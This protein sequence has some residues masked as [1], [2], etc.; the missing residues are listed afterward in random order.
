MKLPI[1]VLAMIALQPVRRD[2]AGGSNFVGAGERKCDGGGSKG[3]NNDA[4]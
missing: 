3:K 1:L 4:K 2:P